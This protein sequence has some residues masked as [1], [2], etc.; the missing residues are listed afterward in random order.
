MRRCDELASCSEDPD[1]LIRTYLSGAMKKAHGLVSGWMEQAGMRVRTDA[2]G[3]LIGTL[4]GAE[5]GAPRFLVGSH[6]DTVRNA[7]RY[8]GMLGVLLGIALAK[9]FKS[10]PFALEVIGFADE[11]G[12]RFGAT[13]FGSRAVSGQ[14]DMSALDLRDKSGKTMR[15]IIRD[16]GLDPAGIPAAAYQP[17]DLLGFL[18]VHIEQGPVLEQL[19]TPVGVVEAINGQSKLRFSFAGQAGHAGTTPMDLRRDALAGAAAF[20][21]E[22][23][24]QASATNGLVATVG[25]LSVTPG[26]SNVIPGE[27][28]L[29]L[30]VRHK[31]DLLRQQAVKQLLGRAQ[32]IASERGLR[33]HYTVLLEEPTAWLSKAFVKLLSRA[34]NL[35]VLTSGAG[36]DCAV[37]S[38]FTPS[39]LL[40]VRS[41]GGLSHHPDETVLELDVAAALDVMQGFLKRLEES[42]RV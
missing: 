18:E 28:A 26:A 15:E 22:A 42:Y 24:A 9:R 40:F 20:V 2:V 41:P 30:D 33:H 11:E 37:M 32:V 23:E 8:D 13:Y 10:L 38:A 16:F 6:L 39:A 14:F 3:N 4:P 36:H 7:G 31:D 34:S 19:D 17:K 5:D 29:S 25:S 12:V 21:L 27:V 1:Q 35:P